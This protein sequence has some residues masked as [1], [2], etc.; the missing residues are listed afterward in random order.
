[1]KN[2]FAMLILGLFPFV[3]FSQKNFKPGYVVT[4]EGDTLKG[5]V[6]YKERGLNPVK[7]NFKAQLDGNSKVFTI[8]D[9]VGYGVN[10]LETFQR[11]LV[12]ISL[13]SE[14]VTNRLFNGL[15]TSVRRDTVLLK[16]LQ[17][18]RNVILYSYQDPIKK[19][20]YI[21]EKHD[22]IPKELIRNVYIRYINKPVIITDN[23]FARQ[24]QDISSRNNSIINTIKERKWADLDYVESDL[25]K[26][27]AEINEQEVVKAKF[28]AT[29]FFIGT[30]LNMS[31]A[32][33]SGKYALSG[34]G[35]INKSSYLPFLTVGIDMF[36]NPA[37]K[38]IIYR[39]ELSFLVG[40]YEM[41]KG[42]YAGSRINEKSRRAEHVFNQYTAQLTPQVIF[43]LYNTPKLK[44]FTSA[45][46]SLN[47]NQYKNNIS[48]DIVT[49]NDGN[50]VTAISSESYIELNSFNYSARFNTGIVLN[51]R[52]EFSAGYHLPSSVTNYVAFNVLVQRLTFGVNFL[53]NKH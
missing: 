36:A 2:V 53:I 44:F 1:M 33:Y 9:C 34:D 42:I 37:I 25:V 8:Q 28:A 40:Q 5:Y 24:L 12:D 30:G 46:V 23:Q 17:K 32:K 41:S 39:A 29:R 7:V 4:N 22:K 35:S 47:L 49:L 51:N 31:K 19:R 48:R 14:N 26:V 43:N 45:G 18:G 27:A 52:L 11:F 6:D 20:F 10:E 15:D 13:S 21:L 16:V 38:K 3:S 50:E